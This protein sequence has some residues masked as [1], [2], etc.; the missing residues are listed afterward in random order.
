MVVI[1]STDSSSSFIT[2]QDKHTNSVS[3]NILNPSL[4]DLCLET[5]CHKS[6]ILNRLTDHIYMDTSKQFTENFVF[7]ENELEITFNPLNETNT[8]NALFKL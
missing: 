8:I 6:F 4:T 7:Y 1:H 2:I 5:F 3:E